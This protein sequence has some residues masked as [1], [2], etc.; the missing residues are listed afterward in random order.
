MEPCLE[1]A[2]A[3]QNSGQQVE[4]G[5][6]I[7]FLA[8]RFAGGQAD[9]ALRH[10]EAGNRIH[11]QQHFGALVAEVFGDGEGHEAGADA[12]GSGTVGGGADHD[13]TLAA[14]GTQLVIEK[15]ANLAIALADQRDHRDVGGIVARHGAQ[16]RAFADAAAAEDSH[17]LAF[18]AGHHGVDGADAGGDGLDDVL[19][20]QRAAGRVV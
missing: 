5:R 17:A 11:N 20:I 7:A 15:G 2:G 19:A 12:Q 14:F 8:G 3:L 4:D 10:G 16:Q 13:G 6:R 9:F 1:V 18:A